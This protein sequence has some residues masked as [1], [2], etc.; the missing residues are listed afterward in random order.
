M[1]TILSA[2]MF[3]GGVALI[4][5]GGKPLWKEIS[6]LKVERASIEST[7]SEL[8]SLQETRDN[9][10]SSYNSIPSS[11][12]EILDQMLPKNSDTGGIL[13]SLEK[14]VQ[15]RGIRLKRAEFKTGDEGSQ[16][17]IQ[18]ANSTH[19]TINL[20]LVVSSTY[21]SF[22]SFLNALEINSR[23]TDINKISFTTAQTNLY[24]FTIESNVNLF[25]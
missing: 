20:S 12:L 19:N 9:L 23:V 13:V 16:K 2:I 11:D 22:K 15:E 25:H 18:L 17:E 8:R 4:F 6:V 24:E 1:K 7:I 21:E 3:L 14:M 5:W 10:L